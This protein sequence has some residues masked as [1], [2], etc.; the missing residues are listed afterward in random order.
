MVLKHASEID[1]KLERESEL[2]K[3]K[4]TEDEGANWRIRS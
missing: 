3:G 1:V 4:L 2:H